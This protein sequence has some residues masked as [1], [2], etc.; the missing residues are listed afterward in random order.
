M[1]LF[2][3]TLHLSE[4]QTTFEDAQHTTSTGG[5]LPKSPLLDADCTVVGIERAQRVAP[6][7]RFQVKAILPLRHHPQ[8]KFPLHL[9]PFPLRSEKRRSMAYRFLHN[10][11][12]VH[13]DQLIAFEATRAPA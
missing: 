9:N 4:L 2:I 6:A 12:G 3:S 5:Q 8:I 11:P 13:V 7:P 10:L 1:R